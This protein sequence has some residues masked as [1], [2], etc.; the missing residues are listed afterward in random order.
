MQAFAARARFGPRKALDLDEVGS[1]EAML[2]VTK[3]GDRLYPGRDPP[4]SDMLVLD[5]R[6]AQLP[7]LKFQGKEQ[8]HCTVCTRLSNNERGANILINSALLQVNPVGKTQS[9]ASIFTAPTASRLSMFRNGE[10]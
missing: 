8:D 2:R 7:S 10:C 3:H 6:H 5:R 4:I 9:N 1:N